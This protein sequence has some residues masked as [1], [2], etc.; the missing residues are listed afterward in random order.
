ME[1]EV[2]LSPDCTLCAVLG[3]SKTR[4]LQTVSELAVAKNPELQCSEVLSSLMAR[5]KMGSTGLGNGIALPHGRIAELQQA[6][7]ILITCKPAIDFDAI[8]N[9]PVDIFFALLVPEEETEAH[10]A[11][12]SSVARKLSDKSVVKSLRSA[13]TREQLLQVM[14]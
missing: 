12:L 6:I 11:T 8:D 2:L 5:E 3:V 1:L 7:A 13:T 10:L 14:I 4:L 9:Q